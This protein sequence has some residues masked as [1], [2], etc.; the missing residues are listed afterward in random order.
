MVIVCFCI[1]HY[2]HRQ[3]HGQMMHPFF[4]T[5][6]SIIFR[7]DILILRHYLEF[8]RVLTSFYKLELLNGL[9]QIDLE[10]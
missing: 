2:A 10:K 3:T 7:K 4:S 9:F 1:K 5:A 6:N 8:G